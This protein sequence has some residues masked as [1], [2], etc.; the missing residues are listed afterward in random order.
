[1]KQARR[2]K[3]FLAKTKRQAIRAARAQMADRFEARQLISRRRKDREFKKALKS[4][5][6]AIMRATNGGAWE[7]LKKYQAMIGA[8]G[9]P[10]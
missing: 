3:L 8:A 9:R 5:T 6:Q 2:K 4:T 10:H 1:M 7:I